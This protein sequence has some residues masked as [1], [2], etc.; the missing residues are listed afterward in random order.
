MTGQSPRNPDRADWIN[1]AGECGCGR[2]ISLWVIPDAAKRDG[3]VMPTFPTACRKC[4]AQIVLSRVKREG[5]GIRPK[6]DSG[7][8]TSRTRP[9]SDKSKASD[10][11][12]TPSKAQIRGIHDPFY[13]RGWCNTCRRAVTHV[14]A[15][16]DVPR[17][18]I[19]DA[20]G[21]YKRQAE[22]ACPTCRDTVA[23]W[24]RGRARPQI[25]KVPS[26][27]VSRRVGICETC[28][29]W[30]ESSSDTSGVLC[31]NDG[32][33]VFMKEQ[34]PNGHPG[35]GESKLRF[36]GHCGVC[37]AFQAISAMKPVNKYGKP[38]DFV[39]APC[40]DRHC[41]GGVSLDLVEG[42]LDKS[43]RCHDA[44]LL[45]GWQAAKKQVGNVVRKPPC[46]CSCRGLN[47]GL[48]MT[49]GNH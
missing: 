6:R 28:F 16:D 40:Q 48:G 20:D 17:N 47:H 32:K 21:Y 36:L 46:R 1:Y 29:L 23:L 39:L 3:R 45:A 31:P 9:S 30:V 37:N 12:A 26:P 8:R 42:R 19:G 44:C 38:R 34:L 15:K 41:S 25:G 4:K 22:A 14:L 13:Y 2:P 7:K 35:A 33:V 27:F 24:L 43:V 18:K 49:L 5:N 11:A 10:L